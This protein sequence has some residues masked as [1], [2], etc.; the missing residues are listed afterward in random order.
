MK[1]SLFL[2]PLLALLASCADDGLLPQPS[3]FVTNITITA[4]DIILDESVPA[5]RTDLAVG[6]SGLEFTWA[7]SDVV[8]IYPNVGD[9]VSFPMTKGAGTQSA[10]FDGGGWAVKANNTYAAYFPYSVDNTTYGRPYTALPFSYTGQRQAAN[11]ST[12]HLG[13]YDYMVA[14]AS[15]PSNGTIGFQFTHI[16]SFLWLQLTTSGAATFTQ[17]TLSANQPVFTE[18]ATVNI[19]TGIITPTTTSKSLTLILDDIAVEAGGTLNAWMAVAPTDLLGKTI[20]ATLTTKGGDPLDIELEGKTLLTGRA[21]I[22]KGPE[23]NNDDGDDDGDGNDDG[24]DDD[25]DASDYYVDLGLTVK[26]ATTNMGA[27]SPEEYGDHYAWGETE[28][29]GTYNWSSYLWCNGSSSS[30]T[31]YCTSSA[32]GKVDGKTALVTEDDVAQAKLGGFWRMPTY[33]EMEELRTKCT[34]TWTTQNGVNGYRVTGT[35]GNSIFLP[36]A[37]YRDGSN[38]SYTGTDGN[39]WTST[40]YMDDSD[41]YRARE[42]YFSSGSVN[43]GR[44]GR[45]V[46]LSVRPVYDDFGGHEYVDLGLSDGTLWATCNVGANSP[47]EDGDLFAW[48]ETEP[49]YIILGTTYDKRHDSKNWKAGNTKGYWWTSYKWCTDEYGRSLTKYCSDSYYGTPDY[50]TVL[51][52]EDDAA[53]VN[54]GSRWRTPTEH[55]WE[56]LKAECT[57]EA[58]FY[59]YEKGIYEDNHTYTELSAADPCYRVTGRNGNYIILPR[60]PRLC[61]LDYESA[62]HC[63]YFYYWTSECYGD[64]Y[65][66][67]YCANDDQ[68]Y[69]SKPMYDCGT[70]KCYGLPVRAVLDKE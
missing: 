35:N 48:G 3:D 41:S 55:E 22:L 68:Y 36:A 53:H 4:S 44:L 25:D 30:L 45:S 47:D 18:Q 42:L 64:D 11:N 63:F 31:K 26:W 50:K 34:W 9:Q 33:K 15:S 5:T 1:K 13:A 52:P 60:A 39:Y 29:K 32:E 57:W 37:G 54:W 16:N 69:S 49:Y 8:G 24:N 67:C 7:A 43:C 2:L 21:Y 17:L 46:G 40:L 66:K 28:T 65:A 6:Q 62:P 61:Q 14:T 59:N 20:T 10:S 58:L 38:L 23:I 27:N 51:D 19:T 56:I 12:A 70:E